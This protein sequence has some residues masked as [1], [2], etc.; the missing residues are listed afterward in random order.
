[1]SNTSLSTN[2]LHNALQSAH[3]PMVFDVR[4]KPA[5]DD[6]PD[7]V[8]GAIWQ[9]HD[10]AHIWA[11]NLPQGTVIVVYCVYGH[12]VSQNASQDLRNLGFDAVF[13]EGGFDAWQHR[14][15]PITPGAK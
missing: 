12:E 3:P 1:M 11:K 14:D 5:F 10:E 9:I 7:T 15:L 6:N 4:K 8:P 13:L 2:Q